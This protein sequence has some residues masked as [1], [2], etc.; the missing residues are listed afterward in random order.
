MYIYISQNK[1]CPSRLWLYWSQLSSQS[2]GSEGLQQPWGPRQGGALHGFLQQLRA[3]NLIPFWRNPPRQPT[4]TVSV[5]IKRLKMIYGYL[6]NIFGSLWV[7]GLSCFGHLTWL[8]RQALKNCWWYCQRTNWNAYPS[9]LISSCMRIYSND[10]R[11][12]MYKGPS[13]IVDMDHGCFL[14]MKT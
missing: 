2:T 13:F 7:Y 5:C 10:W 4:T 9:N 1:C 14:M 12:I 8:W 3:K 11:S 6:Y